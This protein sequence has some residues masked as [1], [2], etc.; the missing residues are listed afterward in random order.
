MDVLTKD[1]AGLPLWAWIVIAAIVIIAVIVVVVVFVSS[2]KKSKAQSAPAQSEEAEKPVKSEPA[3]TEK[4]A[5]AKSEAKKSEL[6]KTEKPAPVKSA[7]K[8]SEPEVE[9]EE[10]DEDDSAPVRND[11]VYHI[12]KRK[13]ENKWQIK[14]AGGAKAIKLFNTQAEAI[15]YA[16]TLADNQEARIM[17][18]KEDG[19]F[20]KLTY[21]K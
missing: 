15:E 3:K 6:A 9:E 8:K 5:P 13:N 12:S 10:V 2:S 16:K 19:S 14:A 7:P 20:R 17:I 18:H 21:K 11:K 1:V 4:S